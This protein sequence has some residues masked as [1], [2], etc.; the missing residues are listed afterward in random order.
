M[1]RFVL[2]CLGTA[3]LS[4]VHAALGDLRA[5][6][7]GYAIAMDGFLSMTVSM[8][9]ETPTPLSSFTIEYW[10]MTTDPHMT[11]QPS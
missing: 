7:A 4:S 1:L 11:Q 6:G 3:L 5:G 2:L 9:L 10:A 8:L